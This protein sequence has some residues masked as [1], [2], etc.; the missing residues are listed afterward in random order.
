M[1]KK[2]LKVVFSACF[3]FAKLTVN[4]QGDGPRAYW[5]APKG[6]QAITPL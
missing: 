5:P 1:I 2:F 6:T 3:A 4:T